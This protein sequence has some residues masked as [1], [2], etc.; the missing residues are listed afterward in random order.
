MNTPVPISSLEAFLKLVWKNNFMLATNV[1]YGST[2]H[3]ALELDF[4]LRARRQ[5]L[6]RDGRELLL[7]LPD[8]P[9]SKA[10]AKHYPDLL[11]PFALSTQ[12]WFWAREAVRAMP[13]LGFNIGMS[14]LSVERPAGELA[15]RPHFKHG[16][17]D[18]LISQQ[19][20]RARGRRNY[21]LRSATADWYP[22]RKVLTPSPALARFLD[23]LG[24][25]PLA[26][27]HIKQM[28]VNASAQ[29]TD[30]A[31]YLPAL[32]RICDLG[33]QPVFAGREVMPD[34]FRAFGVADY[35]GSGI[36]SEADDLALFSRGRI[37]ITAGSGIAHAF[38]IMDV[39]VVYTNSWHIDMLCSSRR[40]VVVPTTMRERQT[41]RP[42]TALEQIAVHKAMPDR[43]LY[44]FPHQTHIPEQ[45]AAEHVREAFEEALRLGH[46]G[47]EPPP[48]SALQ[49]RFKRLDAES[50]FAAG[51]A[52]VGSAWVESFEHRLGDLERPR[53]QE[54]G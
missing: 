8:E 17:L 11:P 25:R 21:A 12:L 40:C 2:G 5:G 7:V 22:F 28:S 26:L 6:V 50:P 34:E 39:P 15:P 35:A 24:D 47:T 13:E 45:A 52:R 46:P 14:H 38:E 31:T 32:G 44:E 4:L 18:F 27:V 37:A 41:G 43:I 1:F 53:E 20:F 42:L 30:P 23:A 3:M 29:A 49:E 36:A 19:A 54:A 16:Q 48:A 10:Y 33:W 51:L 9:F